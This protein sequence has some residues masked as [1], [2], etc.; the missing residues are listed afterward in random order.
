M[1]K[2]LQKQISENK[3]KKMSTN[4]EKLFSSEMSIVFEKM[5]KEKS[6]QS[7]MIFTCFR[8]SMQATSFC[9]NSFINVFSES[10]DEK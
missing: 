9:G 2:Q 4:R 8:K 5:T 10:F 6:F 7:L 1:I 3:R